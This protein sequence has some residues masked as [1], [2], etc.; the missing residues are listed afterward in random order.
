[1]PSRIVVEKP[2]AGISITRFDVQ[3]RAQHILIIVSFF[4]L[5]ITGL[6]LK[7]SDWGFSGWFMG[8]WHGVDNV[9]AVHHWAAWIMI[10]ACAYHLMYILVSRPF[11]TA[12]FPKPKDVKDFIADVKY[13]LRLSKEPPQYDRFSYR[14]KAAYWI[15]YPGAAI[16]I[17]TGL[18]LLYPTGATSYLPGWTLPLALVVHSDAA[19]LATGWILFVHMYFAHFSRHT[20]PFDKSVLT[21]KVPIERY[22]E[23]FPLEY[24]RITAAEGLPAPSARGV[25]QPEWEPEWAD[26][27]E[28]EESLEEESAPLEHTRTR[29]VSQP[30]AKPYVLPV[31]ASSLPS[32][33]GHSE[34]RTMACPECSTATHPFAIMNETEQYRCS[35]CGMVYYTPAGCETAKA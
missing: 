16:M 27:V 33:N 11:S 24:A 18:I 32:S 1:M 10:A 2:K 14:N 29:L 31:R 21:G 8:V 19:I 4:L 28:F 3:Q 35:N 15:V 5:A 26:Q 34:M 22:R 12:M 30:F 6:P 23:E 17:V 20:I 13:T 9:R 7:Y 25:S